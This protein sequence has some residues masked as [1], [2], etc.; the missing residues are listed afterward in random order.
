MPL[1]E[2]AIVTGCSRNERG[3][4]KRLYDAFAGRMLVVCQRY[5]KNRVEAEDVLQEAFVKVFNKIETF[6]F[7]CPLEAR[8]K[9]IVVNTALNYL[10]NQRHWSWM[11]AL[12]TAENDASEPATAPGRLHMDELLTLVRRLPP[13]CQAVFNLYAI[14]GYNHREIADLL[15]VTEGTSKTQYSRAR[16]LLQA[17]LVKENR[18]RHGTQ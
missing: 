9:R 15:G 7:E 11:S 8:V 2:R 12:E 18:I 10:R 14:E 5:T 3:A 13:G 6:R 4:Q 1:D 17:L 16:N